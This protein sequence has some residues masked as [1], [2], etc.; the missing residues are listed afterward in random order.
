M[1]SIEGE[2]HVGTLSGGMDQ[3]ASI[4]GQPSSGLYIQFVPSLVAEAVKL[5]KGVT[6]VICNC[7]KRKEKAVGASQYYNKRVVECR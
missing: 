7:L 6:F 3:S 4:L 1:A 5:P 2:R